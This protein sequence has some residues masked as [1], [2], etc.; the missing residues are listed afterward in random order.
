MR[1]ARRPR[2][3]ALAAALL[4]LAASACWIRFMFASSVI[5]VDEIKKEVHTIIDLV[6]SDSTGAVCAAYS[7]TYECTYIIGGEII[8]SSLYLFSNWGVPGVLVDPLVLQ[9][10]AGVSNAAGTYDDGSGPKP[11]IVTQTSSFPVEPG[12][13]VAAETGQTFLIVE[14]PPEVA[15]SL[16]EGPPDAAGTPFDFAFTFQ[17]PGDQD[18]LVKPMLTVRVDVAGQTFYV[19]TLPCTT[20]FA[21]VPAI[22]I[23]VPVQDQ[24]LLPAVAAALDPDMACRTAVRDY[25]SLDLDLDH[26]LLYK[27]KPAT[28]QIARVTLED[29]SGSAEFDVLATAVLGTPANR[30]ARPTSSRSRPGSARR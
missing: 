27:V 19:P 29:A 1:C 12:A 23:Q 6:F 26:R 3:A 14:L 13:L 30:G 2:L 22:E 28:K 7:G 10:P 9:V 5:F 17:V 21:S 15:A 4:A 25:S 11:L 20:D 8:C 18:L 16:P 24:D